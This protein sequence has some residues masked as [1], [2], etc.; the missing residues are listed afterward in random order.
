MVLICFVGIEFGFLREGM[1]CG[2][3]LRFSFVLGLRLQF[4][5]YVVYMVGLTLWFDVRFLS[6]LRVLCML[7]FVDAC[8]LRVL[9][10][11]NACVWMTLLCSCA[12][13]CICF[14]FLR[15]FK[16]VLSGLYLLLALIFCWVL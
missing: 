2:L 12:V 1:Y 16:S 10:F 9:C 8:F 7:D 4:L 5:V 15:L 3:V 6:L 11:R 14:G 13:E